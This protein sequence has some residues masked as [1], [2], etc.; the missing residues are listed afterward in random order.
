MKIT[1]IQLHFYTKGHNFLILEYSSY[2]W[3]IIYIYTVKKNVKKNTIMSH[4]C[5]LQWHTKADDQLK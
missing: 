4:K 3:N 1:T 2:F 5:I